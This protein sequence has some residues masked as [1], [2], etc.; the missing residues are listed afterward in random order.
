MSSPVRTWTESVIVRSFETGPGGRASLQAIC[1]YLQEAAGNHATELGVAIDQLV[2]KNLTWVVARLRVEMEDYP[3]WRDEIV[4]E[5]WP[6]GA[7]RLYATR[8]FLVRSASGREIARATSAWLLIDLERRRPVRMPEF[9]TS[10]ELPRRERAVADMPD[11]L[12]DSAGDHTGEPS[13]HEIAVRYSDLDMNGHV[14][15]VTFAEWSLE[16][17]PVALRETHVV[18]ALDL[19][20]RAEARYGDTA[21]VRTQ[22]L[23]AN[24]GGSYSF[25]HVITNGDRELA[26]ARTDWSAR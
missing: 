1:N 18:R 3:A 25:L 11:R 15:N 26:R 2:E 16:S 8:E 5:T 6:S 13:T 12:P 7:D 20:F 23:N 4:V 9:I 10:I 17:V 14:N 19:H 22:P 24:S 21:V